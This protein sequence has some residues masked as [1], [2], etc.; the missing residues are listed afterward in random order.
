MSCVGEEASLL[1]R[2]GDIDTTNSYVSRQFWPAGT[3][4]SEPDEGVGCYDVVRG[5]LW[6]VR[7]LAENKLTKML[8]LQ[9]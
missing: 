3:S 8:A 1:M 2:T 7:G 5:G 9:C 4:V 6:H